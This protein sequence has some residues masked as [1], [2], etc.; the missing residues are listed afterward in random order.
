MKLINKLF[1][2]TLITV[3]MMAALTSCSGSSDMTEL[4]PA[5]VQ[6]AARINLRQPLENGGFTIDKDGKITLPDVLQKQLNGNPGVAMPLQMALSA[7]E[8]TDIAECYVFSCKD[9]TDCVLLRLTDADKVEKTLK[10][11]LGEPR[12]NDGTSYFDVDGF[13][14]II[15]DDI[16][17]GVDKVADVAKIKAA[18]K[19]KNIAS[20]S[21]INQLLASNDNTFALAVSP[22]AIDVPQIAKY[23][24][25]LSLKFE[26]N[27]SEGE[28]ALVDADGQR[29]P[30]G[31]AFGTVDT[32]ILNNFPANSNVVAVLGPVKDAS[33][34]KY[35]NKFAAQM[36]DM[37]DL[38]TGLDGTI[39]AAAYIPSSLAGLTSLEDVVGLEGSLLAK[40]KP[41]ALNNIISTIVTK[42]Q[43]GGFEVTQTTNG[44]STVV[45]GS[46]IYF[47]NLDNYLAISTVP[48]TKGGN[49]S[50]KEAIEGTHGAI[51]QKSKVLKSSPMVVD[52]RTWMESDCIKAKATIT[53][54]SKKFIEA[55]IELLLNPDAQAEIENLIRAIMNQYR[56]E[57]GAAYGYGEGYDYD[58]DIDWDAIDDELVFDDNDSIVF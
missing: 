21:S 33:L 28:F 46:T 52:S 53:G 43:L 17:W 35:I 14:F 58:A 13:C 20:I 16:L 19:E 32:D 7:I 51:C 27:V 15:D 30:F 37:S 39:G 41:A 49:T 56:D 54:S 44:Y 36:G 5:D 57:Y 26:G 40:Y 38:L 23:W 2:L 55:Y 48:L 31:D 9:G 18:A 22:K 3:A 50:F 25:C 42:S 12:K 6:F 29:Y 10:T 8:G 47:G 24:G 4:I 11:Y 1:S 45:D 34:K